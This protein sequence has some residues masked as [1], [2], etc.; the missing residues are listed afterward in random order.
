MQEIINNIKISEIFPFERNARKNDNAVKEVIKSIERVGYRTPIIVDENNI[1]LCGHTRYKAI[2]KMGWGEVPFVVRHSDLTE[3]QKKEY[4]IRDNKTGEIA[5]WDFEILEADFSSEE[6]IDFGFD[7][8]STKDEYESEEEKENRVLSDIFIVPPFSILDTRQ[9]YWQDRKRMW[10]KQIGDNGE[11]REGAL[12]NITKSIDEIKSIG[13]KYDKEK[14][15][16]NSLSNGVSLLDPVLAEVAIKWFGLPCCNTFDCFA[17]DSVFGYVSTKCGNSFIGIELRQA[18]VDINNKRVSGMNGKYIC[19]DGRDVLN[20]IDKESQD[21]LFSCPPYYDLEVYSDLKNDASNQETYED[22]LGILEMAFINAVQCLK[23]NRFAFIVVGDIRDKKG[24]Y[25]CFPDDIKRIFKKAGMELYNE[26]ILI[27]M[28]GTLPQRAS[29]YMTSRKVGKCHQNVLVFYKGR[30]EEIKNI[31]P[32][33]EIEG[34]ANESAD[35]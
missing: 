14:V 2:V 5:E 34:V 16:P 15:K 18:Q 33:L 20:H 26:L 3:E 21:L 4:R 31:F 28:L 27:E 13:N 32:R 22:F 25:R 17:G 29:K 19:D 24:N 35:V 7:Q 11:S 9:G 23:Q 6:L 12:V 1:I 8:Y 10:K 30:T